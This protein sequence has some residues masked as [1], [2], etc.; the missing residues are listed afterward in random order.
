MNV[1]IY[2]AKTLCILNTAVKRVKSLLPTHIQSLVW[3]TIDPTT[4]TQDYRIVY[5]A[6]SPHW[7]WGA[8]WKAETNTDA[9]PN[10]GYFLWVFWD[11]KESQRYYACLA[12]EEMKGIL[13]E[14]SCKTYNDLYLYHPN[15]LL[16]RMKRFIY[17]DGILHRKDD[18]LLE[19][20]IPTATAAAKPRALPVPTPAKLAATLKQFQHY[21]GLE[22]CLY[23]PHNLTAAAIQWLAVWMESGLEPFAYQSRLNLSPI[24]T[25][26]CEFEERTVKPDEF[27]FP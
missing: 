20:L 24:T 16:E 4:G 18:T 12:A 23:I 9:L 25:I 8:Q 11:S 21:N 27:L 2:T 6:G 3:F 26:D 7:S 19:L 22:Y 10:T 5:S 15:A 13:Y 17:T 14:S 1:L